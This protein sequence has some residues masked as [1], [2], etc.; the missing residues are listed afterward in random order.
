MSDESICQTQNTAGELPL[1][2]LRAEFRDHLQ[3]RAPLARYTSTRVGGPA[4]VLVVVH[5]AAE[6]EHAART[7]WRMNL[8]MFILGG[9]SNVLV[10]DRG[11]RG[12]VVL[13]H[14]R[15]VHFDEKANPPGVWAESGASFGL[16]SRQAAARGL[17]GL[18]WAVGIPG[19]LG[20]AIVG[21]AG[22]HGA[23]MAGSLVMAEILHR[24]DMEQDMPS[25]SQTWT[26]KQMEYTYRSSMIK[27]HPGEFVVLSALLRLERPSDGDVD[28][29]QARIDRFTEHR[30]S[31]QPQGASMGSIFKNPPGDFAGRLVDAAGL[32]GTRV[33]QAEISTLHGNFFLNRG[34]AKA[35]DI[36]ELIRLARNTVFEKFGISL[37][38]EVEL[39]GEW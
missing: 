9:G 35:Q 3:E 12:V 14:A 10:S 1:E 21:N 33:G 29:I 38:L 26:P 11:V 22:A 13:N 6:L 27:R 18:E 19:T 7:L 16:I 30:R 28:A 39:L 34:G 36:Y 4:D 5:T 20:G 17:G 15:Q 8:P 31:T 23:D 32:K 2:A 24:L 25:R 37:E